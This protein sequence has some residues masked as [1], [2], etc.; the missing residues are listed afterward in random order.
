MRYSFRH[1]DLLLFN[2]PSH[3]LVEL[4]QDLCHWSRTNSSL[5]GFQGWRFKRNKKA[6][7]RYLQFV[8]A[9][10]NPSLLNLQRLC[11][12]HGPSLSLDEQLHWILEQKVLHPCSA[13]S[14][15]RPHHL[16]YFEFCSRPP[17]RLIR[18]HLPSN[19]RFTSF[20]QISN[21]FQNS[22]VH[23]ESTIFSIGSCVL[24]PFSWTTYCS[25]LPNSTACWFAQTKLRLR[26]LGS[27]ISH[28]LL[29][30]T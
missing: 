25:D 3:V 28:T 27:R 22:T 9:R 21:Q 24:W 11:F 17:N 1:C 23:K 13:L 2:I 7:L 14:E 12:E 18:K 19:C 4:F 30:L 6:V 20:C 5:L 10:P 8:Q 15:R 16:Q 26:C 29:N